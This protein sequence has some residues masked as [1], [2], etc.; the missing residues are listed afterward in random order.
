MLPSRQVH[1]LVAD[2]E[3]SLHTVAALVTTRN[4][5]VAPARRFA[6]VMR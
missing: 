3:R 1:N 4:G 5:A 2:D 6:R